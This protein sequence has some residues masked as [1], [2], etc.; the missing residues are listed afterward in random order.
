MRIFEIAFPCEE[1]IAE[2]VVYF[3]IE[4]RKLPAPA[5]WFRWTEDK[6]LSSRWSCFMCTVGYYSAGRFIL[7]SAAS[8]D[9]EELVEWI[10]SYLDGCTA[11]YNATRKFDE[12]VLCGKFTNARRKFAEVPGNWPNL[13]GADINWT[14][15]HKTAMKAPCRS[16]DILSKEVPNEWKKN[17]FSV[18]L[19][20]HSLRDV[21]ELAVGELDL[22]APS[23]LAFLSDNDFA[24]SEIKKVLAEPSLVMSLGF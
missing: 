18:D 1:E 22:K 23:M 19:I 7:I 12:M 5:G 24:R 6:W 4:T 17:R 3:D 14:N 8:N 13:T 15:I 10:E 20:T 11:K 9:E 2:D 21:L 16:F